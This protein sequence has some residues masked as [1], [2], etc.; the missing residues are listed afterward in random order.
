MTQK[1][2][3]I[4]EKLLFLIF[5]WNFSNLVCKMNNSRNKKNFKSFIKFLCFYRS[6]LIKKLMR[7]FIKLVNIFVSIILY[8]FTLK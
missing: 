1:K 4:N 3:K 7:N 5:K 2:I 6:M 8:Q